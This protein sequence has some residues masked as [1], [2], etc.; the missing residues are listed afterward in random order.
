[1]GGGR[2]PNQAGSKYVCA[3]KCWYSKWV[4]QIKLI[5]TYRQVVKELGLEGQ[6]T[7]MQVSNIQKVG[8][9]KDQIQ[10]KANHMA[11]HCGRLVFVAIMLYN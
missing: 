9:R 3:L 7:A 6:V 4:W 10:G 8:Q 5:W 11:G 2:L 1:M